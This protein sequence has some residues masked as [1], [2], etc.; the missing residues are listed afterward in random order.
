MAAIV[1]VLTRALPKES[2]EIEILKQVA[3]FCGAGLLVS[4][5]M[6]TYGLD[7]SVGLF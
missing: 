7:L 3:L 1:R 6:L 5:L 4:V 2:L